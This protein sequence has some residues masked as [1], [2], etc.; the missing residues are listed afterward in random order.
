M[1]A[2]VTACIFGG[3]A[4]QSRRHCHHSLH[5]HGLRAWG[6][7]DC[8]LVSFQRLALTVPTL[9]EKF[10][11]SCISEEETGSQVSLFSV[12]IWTWMYFLSLSGP[13]CFCHIE[14]PSLRCNTLLSPNSISLV[15]SLI[16]TL[17]INEKHLCFVK[18]KYG[19][20]RHIILSCCLLKKKE[21]EK[22]KVLL[23]IFLGSTSVNF[24][25]SSLLVC[26]SGQ[27]WQ[28]ML[29]DVT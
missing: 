22:I 25:K 11:D 12:E 9:R 27:D 24:Q 23:C 14:L 3:D 17:T 10:P 18:W 4:C 20:G 2:R 29:L 1:H 28:A 21:K 7:P 19:P 15:F 6:V 26:H 16:I 8:T 13:T 5:N